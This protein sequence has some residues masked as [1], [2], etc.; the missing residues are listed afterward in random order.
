MAKVIGNI[1]KVTVNVKTPT[2]RDK[3]ERRM[4][5]SVTLNG[6]FSQLIASAKGCISKRDVIAGQRN[7]YL[8]RR[9]HK[10]TKLYRGYFE[11]SL[12]INTDKGRKLDAMGKLL[13]VERTKSA[14][15]VPFHKY[16]RVKKVYIETDRHYR[17]RILHVLVGDTFK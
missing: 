1:Q 5:L 8:Y 4:D 13:G 9:R 14:I 12:F 3:R 15:K 6:N 16:H 17:R 10:L 2:E 11:S 7:R